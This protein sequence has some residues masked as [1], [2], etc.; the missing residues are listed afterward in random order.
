MDELIKK[1]RTN[2]VILLVL[3]ILSFTW[4]FLDYLA[5]KEIRVESLGDKN[6]EW[7]IVLISAIPF[8]LFHLFVFITIFYIFR[9]KGKF[10]SF[11]KKIV[12]GNKS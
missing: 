10:R 2:S 8:F 12:T 6:F 5:L 11:Q 3:G 4:L 1:L 9:L 7:I